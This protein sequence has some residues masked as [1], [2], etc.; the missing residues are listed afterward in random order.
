AWQPCTQALANG[1]GP[2]ASKK[3]R[4]WSPASSALAIAGASTP[5][6][7]PWWEHGT[8]AGSAVAASGSG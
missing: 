4:G 5:S 8:S 3:A 2:R 1:F 7:H 6:G